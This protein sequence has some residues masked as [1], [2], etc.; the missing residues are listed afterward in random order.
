MTRRKRKPRGPIGGGGARHPAS[1][2]NL[3]PVK[4][5]PVGNSLAVKHGAY[6]RVTEAE[7]EGKVA[8]VYRAL[9]QDL[10]LREPDGSAPAADT[11]PLR[12]LAKTLVRLDR[13]ADFVARRGYED[14]H[15]KLREVVGY[16]LK[17]RGH[18]LDLARELGMTPRARA[19][20]GVDVVRAAQSFDLARHWQEQG[21]A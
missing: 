17:L 10:P 8:E 21:D 20:L 18:A 19:A 5:G 13:I 9:G 16:E 3:R 6:A 1:L 12:L 7:L 14:E 2:A 11:V 4:G 15:G